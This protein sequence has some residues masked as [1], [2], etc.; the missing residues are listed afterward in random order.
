MIHDAPA[1]QSTTS[2]LGQPDP[3]AL[4]TAA[5]WVMTLSMTLGLAAVIGGI[6]LITNTSENDAG[7][8]TITSHPYAILGVA[9]L[10][11][12]VIQALVI[13]MLAQW[14]MLYAKIAASKS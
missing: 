1:H 6:S 4:H 5:A 13:G 10:I 9:I 2:K 3:H 7:F 14:A 11:T 8:E 12:G